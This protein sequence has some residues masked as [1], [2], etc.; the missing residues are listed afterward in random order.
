MKTISDQIKAVVIISADIEW[1][2]IKEIFPAVELHYSPFGEWFI[3]NL[4]INADYDGVEESTNVVYFHG[5]W[6]KISAAASTQFVIDHWQPEL[7][8]NLGTCGW[9]QGEVDRDVIILAEKTI[10]YDIYE[11][12]YPT[13]DH[14]DHYSTDIN[15]EWLDEDFP[16]QVQ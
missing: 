11:L 13:Q 5:G 12:M 4:L 10:V 3:D 9:F 16:L 15:V 6:G 14:V 8:L 2:V 7:L 1:R